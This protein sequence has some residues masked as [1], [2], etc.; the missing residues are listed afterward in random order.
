[1]E[2]YIYMMIIVIII[3]ILVWIYGR[4]DRGYNEEERIRRQKV[5]ETIKWLYKCVNEI[6]YNCDMEPVYEIKESF[7][8]TYSEKNINKH[9]IKGTIYLV[10]WND[11]Y[12]R[13]FSR[14]T[15]IYAVLHEIAHILSPSINHKDPFDAIEKV[16]LNK[17]IE[18]SYYD[19][20]VQMEEN[21]LT[22]DIKR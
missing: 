15:L 21:Y 18:L 13:V 5:K 4:F 7:Q 17:A 16:L 11:K 14:N 10:I 9:N 1:M 6:C 2:I 12:S 22:L 8:I 19:P 20:K 3:I